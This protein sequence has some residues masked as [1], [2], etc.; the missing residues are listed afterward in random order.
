MERVVVLGS[1]GAG[2][3]TFARALSQRIGLPLVSIDALFWRPGWVEPPREEFHARMRE[4]M[5]RPSWIMDGNYMSHGMGPE[6]VALA[7]TIILFDLPTW[8]CVAGVLGRVAKSYGKVRPEMA[9]GC[10]ER[11]DF[12]FLRF[13]WTFRA[14]QLPKLEAAVAGR[15]VHRFRSRGEARSFLDTVGRDTVAHGAM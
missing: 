3:S 4:E 14:K 2:K 13:V 7:D 6:R 9:P 8:V 5:A 15:A 10:P 12:P 11:L 1:S